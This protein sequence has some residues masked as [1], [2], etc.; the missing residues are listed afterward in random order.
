MAVGDSVLVS[1]TVRDFYPLSSGDSVAT[2]S[3]LSVTEIGTPTVIVRSHGNATAGAGGRRAQPVP[4]TYAPD[5][6]GGNIES[7]PITPDAPPWTT[8]SRARACAWTSTT[9]A[10]SGR[11]NNFG[12]HYVHRRSRRQAAT[13]P[14]RH[15][16]PG[17]ERHPLGPSRGRPVS[18]PDPGVDVGDVAPAPPSGRLDYTQF[19]GYLIAP[20]RLGDRAAQHLARGTTRAGA[21]DEL[22][23]ATYNVEN[24]DPADGHQVRRAWPRRS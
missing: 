21:L 14:R 23:V 1:G 16:D 11:P 18:G 13:L 17:R 3:N 10:W 2:T 19:G 15:R 7:T 5:L 22:A 9:L 24:L 6:N 12:E 4:D 8:G 20:R